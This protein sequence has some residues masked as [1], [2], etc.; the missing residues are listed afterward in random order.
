MIRKESHNCTA[1]SCVR[2]LREVAD[3]LMQAM[4]YDKNFSPCI[5]TAYP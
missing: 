2:L 1:I 5:A 4:D 3:D